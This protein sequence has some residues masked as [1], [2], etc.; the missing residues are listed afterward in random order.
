MFGPGAIAVFA[1]LLALLTMKAQHW[2]EPELH[3]SAWDR[4]FLAFLLEDSPEKAGLPS[5]EDLVKLQH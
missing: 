4:V 1:G 3:S 5:A 2:D